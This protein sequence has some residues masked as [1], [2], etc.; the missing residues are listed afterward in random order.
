[1]QIAGILLAGGASTRMGTNKLL[2]ELGGEP[3]VRRAARV[4]LASGLDPV[5]LVVGHD[6]DRVSAAVAGLPLRIVANPAHERGLNTS[7]SA[8]VAAVPPA[9]AAAVVLLADMPL[10]DPALVGDLVDW[11]ARTGAPV[12]SARYAGTVAPPVLYARALLP[13]LCG[14]EGE[15]RGREVVRRHAD[16][17]AFVDR[18]ASA[19]AD[20]DAP[21]DLEAVRAALAGEVRP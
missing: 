15:G 21:G 14:A 2:V 18:P 17:A 12:V 5:L 19:L 9:A 1:M 3:L 6:L 20:V 7:L 13:E 10:V 11:H 16:R 8:G 4:A